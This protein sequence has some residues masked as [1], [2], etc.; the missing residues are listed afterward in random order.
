MGFLSILLLCKNIQQVIFL[1]WKLWHHVIIFNIW[2]FIKVWFVL[3]LLIS[4]DVSLNP[5]PVE[6]SLVVSV[7]IWELLNKEGLHFLHININSLLRKSDKLKCIANK[8]KATII[9]ITESKLD[10]PVSDIKVNLPEYDSLW[11]DR[12]KIG[13]GVACYIR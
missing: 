12:N 3:L 8:N 11:Y 9:G 4:G 2:H 5:R 1:I 7:N 13:G 6:V 10:H